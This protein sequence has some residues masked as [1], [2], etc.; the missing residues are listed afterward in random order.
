V[1][2]CTNQYNSTVPNGQV[3]SWTPTGTALEGATISVIVSEGP[4]PVTVPPGLVGMTVNQA[5]AALLAVGLVPAADGPLV[6]HVFDSSPAPGTS[7]APGTTV[8]LYV[9]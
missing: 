5:T 1:A 7:V 4:Q 2:Q 8:T 6:G 3:V 9:K